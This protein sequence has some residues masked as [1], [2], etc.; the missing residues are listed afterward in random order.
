M[1][2]RY[3]HLEDSIVDAV[4]EACEGRDVAV[5][6][7]GGL[8]SG[9]VA[10]LASR[11]ADSVHLYTCGTDN[12]FDVSKARELSTVL[13]L[14]WT[15]LRLTRDNVEDSIR[16]LMGS[17]GTT[18]PFTVSYEL[19]LYCVCRDCGEAVVLTG[20]GADEY[21]MGSAKFVGQPRDVYE[22]LRDA[23]I[24]R[25]WE[26][27]VPC[28]MAIAERFSRSLHHPY[29]ADGVTSE[30]LTID[31]T[32]DV[33]ATMEGRK[34]VLKEVAV[35]LGVPIL[36]G[37]IKKSSQYGSGTTD[38]VRT[39]ARERGM[40]YNQYIAYL[41]GDVGDLPSS[42]RGSAVSARVD[43]VLKAEAERIIA[44]CGADPSAVVDMLYRRIVKE[45]GIGFL[46]DVFGNGS[47]DTR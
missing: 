41:G 15:H 16:G 13:D 12:A 28:E 45:G 25:L 10:A 3:Q 32:T 34:A 27:S 33:P 38:L 26:V 40:Q 43:S 2:F 37:R 1:D 36:A 14:P 46:S 4:R 8:D 7:S 19:Q 31:P 24:R 23:G 17:T 9:L 47:D 44:E 11:Y 35:H 39:L 6:F 21:F 5:A 22:P 29:L 42:G 18:D 20:Q 30:A